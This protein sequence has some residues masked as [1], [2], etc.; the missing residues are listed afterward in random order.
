ML[1]IY[2]AGGF[3]L[4][5]LDT[6]EALRKHG[7]EVCFVRDGGNGELCGIPILK[8]EEVPNSAVY[9]IAIA[10]PERRVIAERLTRFTTIAAATAIISDHAEIGE[11]S[12]IAHH[13][14]VEAKARIGKH[15][16]ANI[17]S[18]V[19][20]DCRIGDFVTF[21]PRV[22]CNGNVHIESFAY[23]GAGAIIKQGTPDKPLRI[24]KGAVVG[25]GSVV[26]KD[27]PP[28]V[29]V[30]GNPARVKE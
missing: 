18:Y 8:P 28:G 13:A 26:T 9:C 16:Q 3:A 19:A 27:V 2:G 1:A 21:A 12:L 6:F 10:G 15:F 20:H 4:Q 7:R 22:S 25:M 5:M 29:T 17:Y 23:I 30:M 11:G 24:G 14:I